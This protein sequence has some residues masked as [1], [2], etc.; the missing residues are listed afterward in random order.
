[1]DHERL[2]EDRKRSDSGTNE[3]NREER[4]CGLPESPTPEIKHKRQHVV[5]GVRRA[6]R[7]LWDKQQPPDRERSES[8][9]TP[10]NGTQSSLS[11]VAK[12]VKRNG[13]EN[14]RRSKPNRIEFPSRE[15]CARG[16]KKDD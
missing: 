15:S 8:G 12:R 5:E 2:I 7:R 3:E 6:V 10:I 11:R 9:D 13:E 14:E 1:V 4:H 16:D